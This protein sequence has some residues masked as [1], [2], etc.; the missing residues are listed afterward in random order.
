MTQIMYVTSIAIST[1]GIQAGVLDQKALF[2]S[3]KL[4][5]FYF[6]GPQPLVPTFVNGDNLISTTSNKKLSVATDGSV[7]CLLVGGYELIKGTLKY[8]PQEAI[9]GPSVLFAK[10]AEGLEYVISCES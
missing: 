8:N 3:L 9:S 10:D 5:L 7:F 6:A 2:K 1:P 4:G